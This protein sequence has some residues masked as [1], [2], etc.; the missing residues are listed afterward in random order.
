[1]LFLSPKNGSIALGYKDKS[2][3]RHSAFLLRAKERLFRNF[4]LIEVQNAG[5]APANPI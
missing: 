4:N 3:K 1:M 2:P 5:D